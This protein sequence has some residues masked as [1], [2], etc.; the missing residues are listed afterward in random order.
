MPTFEFS[1]PNGKV[2]TI[3]G[4]DGATQEQAFA[5]LQSR[6]MP[7]SKPQAVPQPEPQSEPSG[8]FRQ[9]MLDPL[10][11][12]EQLLRKALPEGVTSS[13]DRANNFLSK[14][15]GG[16]I[17]PRGGT[18]QFEEAL[19]Q[20][21]AQYQEG[22]RAQGDTG[23]DWDRLAGSLVNP[24]YW[25]VGG[26]LM[27]QGATLG[28]KA[29]LGMLGGA[30]GAALQP[31]VEDNKLGQTIIGGLAGA[32]VPFAGQ[33]LSRIISPKS[34]PD[35]QML[36]R[37]G[38]TP[39]PGQAAG[40]M[41][42][43]LEDVATSAPLAGAGIIKA[44]SRVLEDFNRAVGNRV[45]S[46]IDSNLPVYAKTGDDI[47]DFLKSEI[48]SS[49]DKIMPRVKGKLDEPF[50]AELKT[51]QAS[52]NRL[53]LPDDYKK[54][55]NH[56][57]DDRILELG[58]KGFDTDAIKSIKTELS[59]AIMASARKGE[60][61]DATI[62][63]KL[64]DIDDAFFGMLSRHSGAGTI[65]KLKNAD[66]AYKLGTIFRDAKI[67]PRATE[68]SGTFTPAELGVS[69]RM[70]KGVS[71][72][73]R[74]SGLAPL[75][76]IAEAGRRVIGQKEP[77]S[78]TAQRLSTTAGALLAFNNLLAAIK[79]GVPLGAIGGLYAIPKAQR[80]MTRLV[81]ER[82][83]GLEPVAQALEQS[84]QYLAPGLGAESSR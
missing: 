48:S 39:T 76:D 7:Q 4:P 29:G 72:S 52:A 42:Q 49:Y 46:S 75:Q 84:S 25:P 77:D 64:S 6:L 40:G 55:I 81:T 35:V 47:Y 1:S 12:G 54:I 82:P 22:R 71:K 61:F 32:A 67:S 62:A 70:A 27:G 78:G 14:M 13:I 17:A 53:A 16:A 18:P 31:D 43:R 37:E 74:A 50:L 56:M 57:V 23:I 41:M 20:R 11:G 51:I 33:A 8:G 66:A 65:Q 83:P 24:I 69:I 21:E 5:I 19:K 9:A 38:I 3:E 73:R 80:A 63:R 15:T 44:R 34:S 30:S 68:R 10:Y 60:Y 58:K 26:G 28:A 36:M 59:N 79:L 45:L 2:Y